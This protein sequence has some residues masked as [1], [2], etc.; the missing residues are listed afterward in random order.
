VIHPLPSELEQYVLGALVGQEAEHLE[1]HVMG[2]SAC[3]EEL[4]REALIEVKLKEA[5]KRLGSRPARVQRLPVMVRAAIGAGVALAASILVVL[6]SHR[7]PSQLDP[8]PPSA[9]ALPD[10]REQL[11]V[12]NDTVALE[13]LDESMAGNDL[14]SEAEPRNDLARDSRRAATP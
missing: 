3:A 4:A 1:A 7:P 8:F 13:G 10:S 5:V 6:A 2:C 14:G 11:L 9:S 12:R